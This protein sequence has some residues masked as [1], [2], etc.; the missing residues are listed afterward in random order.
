M[1]SIY[2]QGLQS[3]RNTYWMGD[4]SPDQLGQLE[5]LPGLLQTGGTAFGQYESAQAADDA[6]KAEEAKKA[7]A[8]AAAAAAATNAAT[9]NAIIN[10]K[11]IMGLDPGVFWA[12]AATV[13]IVSIA[14]AVI[15]SKKK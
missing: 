6:R 5:W 8:A 12:G 3:P 13:G 14:A 11:K 10:S 2:Y 9:Q 15:A 7:A 1:K 4:R